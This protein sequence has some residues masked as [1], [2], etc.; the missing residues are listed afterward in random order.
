M[1]RLSQIKSLILASVSVTALLIATSVVIP[2]V[3]PAAAQTNV[4]ISVEFQ[5]ALTPYGQ[6]QSEPRWGEVWIPARVAR[7]WQPYTNGNWIYSEDY[8]WYWISSEEEA[9][10]GWVA[11]HYGRWINWALAELGASSRGFAW[12][13]WRR[14]GDMPVGH[15]FPTGSLSIATTR[16]SGCSCAWPISRRRTYATLSC[17]FLNDR[18]LCSARSS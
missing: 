4:A 13:D 5:T 7:D 16:S 1:L 9:E 8:G 3:A 10:W 18:R 11:F 17:H 15:R 6:W 14:S 12:V 2:F